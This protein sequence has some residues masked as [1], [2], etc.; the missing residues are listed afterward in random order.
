[1][2]QKKIDLEKSSNKLEIEIAK[3]RYKLSLLKEPLH[4]PLNLF[5]KI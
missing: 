2:L 3:K 5:T 4:D 1:M